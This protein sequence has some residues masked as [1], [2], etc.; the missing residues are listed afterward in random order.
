MYFSPSCGTPIIP[1]GANNPALPVFSFLVPLISSCT[2]SP[3]AMAANYSLCKTGKN[4]ANISSLEY[5]I[6]MTINMISYMDG[7][8]SSETG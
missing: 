1:P 2:L 7:Y 5:N 6:R 8:I 3:I 4:C